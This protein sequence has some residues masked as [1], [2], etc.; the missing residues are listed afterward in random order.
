M[1]KHAVL[2]ALL[3][4]ALALASG[5]RPQAAEKP[6]V[7]PLVFNVKDYGATGIKDDLAQEA[8]Q[9]AIDACAASGGGTVLVPPG[10]YTSGT[11]HLRSHV[12]LYL[13]GGATLYALHDKSHFDKDAL[14]YGEDLVGVTIE[15]RGVFNGEGAYDRRLKGDHEDDFIRPNQLEMEALG[16]PLMRSF[17][18]PDQYGKLVLLVRCTGRPHRRPLVPR[19]PVLDHAPRPVRAGGH[20]RGLYPDEPPGRRLGR[21]HRPRR[22]QG[23][24][25]LQLHHR[26][27]R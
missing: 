8:I 23:R 1:S 11:I 22:L 12:R 13:E 25:D 26:D 3:A 7:A 14:L 9:K 4:A 5:C 10:D 16:L 18:K 21:R 17:P 24:P 20:R 15:G 19:F 6:A 27:G 2:T